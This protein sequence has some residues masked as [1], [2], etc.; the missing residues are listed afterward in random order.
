VFE[1]ELH[2]LPGD[3][4]VCAHCMT[5]LV[6]NDDLTSRGLTPDEFLELPDD[7]RLELTRALKALMEVQDG[8]H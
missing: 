2:P 8:E 7:A 5:F 4:S 6:F 1:K 3:L